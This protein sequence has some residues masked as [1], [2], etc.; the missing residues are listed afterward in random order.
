MIRTRHT[1]TYTRNYC[2]RSFH[3]SPNCTKIVSGWGSAPDPAGGAYSAPP[4]PLAVM[5][6][7]GDL[8]TT[9]FGCK[10]CAPLLVAG[11]P[12]LFWGWLRAWLTHEYYTIIEWFLSIHWIIFCS[13][14]QYQ[15]SGRRPRG[16]YCKFEQNIIQ[17]I[18]RNHS[19][20]VLSHRLLK[21]RCMEKEGKGDRVMKRSGDSGFELLWLG[22]N[23]VLKY[24]FVILKLSLNY[25]LLLQ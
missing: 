22:D 1:G 19:I 12:L 18:L 6:W 20:I 3:F 7:D 15:P 9:F 23:K 10:L 25:T 11:A 13:N 2:T 4:D 16:W 21:E 17:C 5:G 14:L 8:V 24:H